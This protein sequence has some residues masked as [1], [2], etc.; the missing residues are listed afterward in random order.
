M[1]SKITASRDGVSVRIGMERD[2]GQAGVC[3]ADFLIRSLQGFIAKRSKTTK[4][5][6]TRASPVSSQAEA[7]NI[8][9]LQT[10]WNDDFFRE[11]KTS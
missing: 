9:V 11:L 5:K 2:P 8:K 6:I 1:P 3:E 10:S 7:G 4:E